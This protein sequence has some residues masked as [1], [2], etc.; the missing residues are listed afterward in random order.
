MQEKQQVGD[1]IFGYDDRGD[2]HA[3]A[4]FRKAEQTCFRKEDRGDKDICER[5]DAKR[6]AKEM[7]ARAVPGGIPRRIG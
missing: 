2:K 1:R 4:L 7:T 5:G 6:D 3:V